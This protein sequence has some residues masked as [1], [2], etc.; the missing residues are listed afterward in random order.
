[1]LRIYALSNRL[2][3]LKNLRVLSLK[4]KSKRR[5]PKREQRVAEL[6]MMKK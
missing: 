6:R 2:R 3:G 1:M 4:R 5:L